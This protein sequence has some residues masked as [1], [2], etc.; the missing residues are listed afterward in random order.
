MAVVGLDHFALP[1]AHETVLRGH[2]RPQG[3]AAAQAELFGHLAIRRRADRAHHLRQEN[4]G[5]GNRGGRSSGVHREGERKGDARA[6]KEQ[7]HSVHQP[8]NRAHRRDP[9]VFPGP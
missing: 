3:R 2:R 7:R 6:A 8:R 4:P 1:R 9:S 5:T